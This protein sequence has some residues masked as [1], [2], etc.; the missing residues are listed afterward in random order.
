MSS[1]LTDIERSDL[2]KR[3]A[4]LQEHHLGKRLDLALWATAPGGHPDDLMRTLPKHFETARTLVESEPFVRAGLRTYTLKRWTYNEGR[5]ALRL[6]LE[7]GT[8]EVT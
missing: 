1:P 7:T 3:I 4:S 5:I 8:Y 2:G 6:D